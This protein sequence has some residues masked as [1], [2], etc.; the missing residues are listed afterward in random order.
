MGSNREASR[1]VQK[2][3]S[4]TY[5]IGDPEVG[6]RTRGKPK[7]NYKMVDHF[8][9]HMSFEFEMSLVGKLT[10]FLGLHVK[11]T[12]DRTFISLTKYDKNLVKKFGLE[13][14]THH[15]TLI[16]T[17]TKI[18]RNKSGKNVDQTLYRSMIG[19]LL[20]LIT[21]KPYLCYSVQICARYQDCPKESH[22]IS[23]KKIIKYVSR[24]TEFRV[25]YPM[26][27]LQP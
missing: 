15:R 6:V 19:S 2:Y 14:A 12:S 1:Q 3:H 27:P 20:Y 21:S 23:I 7:V 9:K 11:Q 25:W 16:G 17:H 18:S 5:I 22:L 24:T 10:Y 4:T 8:V 13:Y 26:T